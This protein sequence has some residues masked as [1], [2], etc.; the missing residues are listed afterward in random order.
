MS[1]PAAPMAPSA[2]QPP[3]SEAARVVDTFIAPSKT[4]ADIRRSAR[5][6]VPWLL[7]AIFSYVFVAAV[8][9]KV[10]W[11][12]VVQNQI[13][14]NPKQADKIDSM[15]ASQRQQAL[16]LSVSITKG[17][18]YAIPIV[19]IIF[20]A[21]IALVFMATFNFM[22]GAEIGFGQALAV[23]MYA[24]LPSIVKAILAVVSLYAGASPESFVIDNPVASNLGALIDMTT[25]PALFRLLSAFDIFAIWI[26]ILEGIGF[27][28]ISKV[29]RSTAIGVVFGWYALI[30]LLKVGWAAAFS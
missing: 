27:A 1:T 7:M 28:C 20:L 15:P 11:D 16:S 24:W 17:I 21:I 18:S 22:L 6:L 19:N 26:L 13:R 25:H 10:G 23:V 2:E 14:Q 5:W 12:Q 8:A 4:F 3:L 9:Q 30:V 29:K